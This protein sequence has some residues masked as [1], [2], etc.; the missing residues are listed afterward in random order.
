MT[1][2]LRIVPPMTAIETA[3]WTTAEERAAAAAFAS[4]RR[5]AEFLTWRAVVRRELGRDVRIG[6]DELGAPRLG[7]C[8]VHISVS[9]CAGRVAVCFSNGPCA[10]DI[11]PETRNF[12][13]AASRY[14]TTAERELSDDPLLPG[15][16]W[17]A[18]EAL[19]KYSG[20]GELDWLN[21]L[22]IERIDMEGGTLTGRIAGG[23]PVELS[24]RREEGY[25][26]VCIF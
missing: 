17:C 21:D 23:E 7:D 25:I 3:P 19:Y 1:P 11:E 18:K 22:R 6:Y 13:R 2:F 12:S 8:D 9:H 5:R 4:E 16:I 26:I 24:L 14:I 10:V 20:R 15:I